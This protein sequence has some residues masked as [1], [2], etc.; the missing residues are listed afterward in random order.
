MYSH[1]NNEEAKSNASALEAYVLSLLTKKPL[2]KKQK[3]TNKKK[4]LVKGEQEELRWIEQFGGNR[5]P[6]MS[7][8]RQDID[9]TKAGETH[10]ITTYSIK[11]QFTSSQ[12]YGGI[13]LE[14]TLI[15]PVT[16]YT[17]EGNFLYC[18]AHYYGW[19]V[20]ID[21]EPHWLKMSVPKFKEWVLSKDFQRKN[22]LPETVQSNIDQ[23]RALADTVSII[24]PLDILLREFKPE[25]IKA[26]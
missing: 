6:A 7:V 26:I 18:K 8:Q 25:V 5:A 2:T 3:R 22:L 23:G 1:L 13:T 21:N 15:N 24:V 16:G 10:G 11:D 12:Q 19:L 4:A 17:T 9:V 20:S 14:E